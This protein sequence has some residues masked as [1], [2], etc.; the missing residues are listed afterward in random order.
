[1]RSY[2]YSTANGR[3]VWFCEAGALEARDESYYFGAFWEEVGDDWR[4]GGLG[5]DGCIVKGTRD[6]VFLGA[7]RGEGGDKA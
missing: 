7:R 5:L 6:F 2:E 4:G 3:S 1:M